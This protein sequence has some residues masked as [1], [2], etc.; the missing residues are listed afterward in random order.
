[1][2]CYHYVTKTDSKGKTRKEKRVTHRATQYFSFT[3]WSDHSD[4]IDALFFIEKLKAVRLRIYQKFTFL[5][6][7]GA[8]LA[9]E[10]EEFKNENRKDVH[11]DFSEE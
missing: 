10:R 3:E 5:P 6:E 9:Q 1:M 7:V 2:V 11:N 4:N 8:R